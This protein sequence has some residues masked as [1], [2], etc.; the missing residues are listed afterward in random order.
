MNTPNPLLP[1]GSLQKTSK[2]RSTV[3]IAVFSIV[4]IHAVFFSGL[5]WQGC[6]RDTAKIDRKS[7]E[8]TNSFADAIPK[9]ESSYYSNFT[10]IPAVTT[11]APIASVTGTNPAAPVP[12]V[13]STSPIVTPGASAKTEPSPESKSETKEY[14]V[15]RGD[16]VGN[17]AKAHH[18]SVNAIVKANPGLEPSHIRVG[19][20]ILIPAV[21]A[22]SAAASTVVGL[23]EPASSDSGAGAT[24]VVK[25]ND[26][27]SKIA[28]Q[29]GTTVEA[30][31]SANK[32]KSVRLLVGQKLK[33][34]AGSSA[35]GSGAGTPR[36]LTNPATGAMLR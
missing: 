14:T 31:K 6:N 3:S 2:G 5:L 25:A 12:G 24:Y 8:A 28:K 22:K 32:L 35:G 10:E 27:L 30:I 11:N 1:Q 34:P 26:N 17:I 33:L 16:T 19:Q 9:L 18:S 20:K 23:V 7:S 29:H 15:V 4:A 13:A 36:T 21:A